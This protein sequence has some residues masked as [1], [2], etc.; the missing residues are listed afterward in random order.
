LELT[1]QQKI[2]AQDYASGEF[3]DVMLAEKYGVVPQTL[4]NWRQIPEVQ[5]KIAE[6]KSI[7]LKEA[8]EYVGRFVRQLVRRQ[9]RVAMDGNT[10]LLIFLG[11][12][13]LG[14]KDT[15]VL[16]HFAEGITIEYVDAADAKKED[17]GN[18][19]L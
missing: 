16:E 3:T 18:E 5:A 2:Y 4:W 19:S 10:A 11:K 15:Q 13:Y 7:Y 8:Q 17:S 14:Q 12:N 9:Y 1:E 6:F